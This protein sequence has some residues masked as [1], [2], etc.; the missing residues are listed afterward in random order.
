MVSAVDYSAIA[1][2]MR[3]GQPDLFITFT[4]NPRWPEIQAALPP[5]ADYNHHADATLREF[6][7]K[8]K[9]LI[10][11]IVDE[12]IFGSVLAYV[13]RVEWQ[14]RG[15]PHAHVLFIMKDNVAG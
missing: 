8:L 4:C 14:A 15:L 10:K 6:M 5:G 9:Q 13:C 7:I 3:F 2:P 11:D 1:L 12:A